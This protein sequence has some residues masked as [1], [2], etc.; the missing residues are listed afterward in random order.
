MRGEFVVTATL[1]RRFNYLLR[2]A[3]LAFAPLMAATSPRGR[4]G[5]GE[6]RSYNESS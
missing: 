5:P 4:G 3:G 1:T 6:G 2:P